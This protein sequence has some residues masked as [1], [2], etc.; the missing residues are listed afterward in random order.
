VNALRGGVGLLTDIA[1]GFGLMGGELGAET[2]TET[3]IW[4]MG[5][6]RLRERANI[7]VDSALR[8]VPVS[9]KSMRLR[10]LMPQLSCGGDCQ[11]LQQKRPRTK[12][13]ITES[14]SLLQPPRS[15]HARF[16]WWC[17]LGSQ[18][19]SSESVRFW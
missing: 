11:A 18:D 6:G 15:R 14:V 16:H 2:G 17:M 19:R 5:R 9:F 12:E 10:W 4:R 7:S 1:R 13:G 3:G 8:P